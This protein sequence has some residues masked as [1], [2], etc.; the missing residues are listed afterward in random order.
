[1]RNLFDETRINSV[2]LKNRLVRSATW[3]NMADGNGHMTEKLFNLYEDL[4]QGDV[5]M[6][7]SGCTFVMPGDQFYPGMMGM[8]EDSF[9]AEYKRLTEIVH[10]HG[11]RIVQQLAYG[12]TQGTRQEDELPVWGPSNVAD[13]AT[14]TVPTPM[15]KENIRTLVKAFG[16]AAARAKAAGFDGVQIHGS[17]G[18]LLG[19]FLSPHYNRRSDKYGGSIENRARIYVEVYEEIRGRVGEDFP[20]MLKINESDSIDNG[21]TFEDCLYVSKKLDELGIDALEISGGTAASGDFM[22]RTKINSPEKEG[23]HA[24][25][26][27]RI[28]DEVQAPVILVG[29]LRSPEVMETLLKNTAIEYFSLSRPLLAEPDLPRRWQQVDRSPAKCISCNA[30][31]KGNPEGNICVL[32]HKF[33]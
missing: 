32:K 17:H 31:Q 29:G 20:V 27:A 33:T 1:M 12:G 18:Y 4:A 16:D 13:L 8:W 15:S 2:V 11:S 25:A 6:I 10:S 14:G 22:S 5:G 24:E 7:I 3:E 19:Q 26:A 28:A 30:C 9:I 23:Y 21:A